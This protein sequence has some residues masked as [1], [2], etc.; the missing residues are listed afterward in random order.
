M[1][2]RKLLYIRLLFA[3]LL[4]L[5]AA[6]LRGQQPANPEPADKGRK[7]F[8]ISVHADMVSVPITVRRPESGFVKGLPQSAFHIY[9][10]G[11]PQEIAYFEQEGLPTGIAVVLDISGSVRSEWGAIKYATIKFL[12]NL[13]PEDQFSLVT[14]NTEIRLKM[15]WGRKTDRLNSVLTSIYCKD[16]TKLWDAIWITGNDVFKNAKDAFAKGVEYKKAM[17]IM[18]DGLDNNSSVS[19]E[20]ALQSAVRSGAAVYIVSKTESIRQLMEFE[21]N[22]NP[23]IS[24]PQKE[25]ANAEQALQTLAYKTGGRMLYPNNFGQLDNIYAQVDEELRNQ[26]TVGYYSTNKANDGSY[27]NI[28]V[29][30]QSPGSQVSARPGYYALNDL[31]APASSGKK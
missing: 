19:Y 3:I 31:P 29:R 8:Q 17:I 22:N 16:N 4:G 30:V 7:E 15:D 9:E 6:L 24:I 20:E 21:K 18:T 27:R 5:A 2:K 25:F 11:K 28:E 23:Y 12:E 1:N 14:F 26:Y 13:K 10:D